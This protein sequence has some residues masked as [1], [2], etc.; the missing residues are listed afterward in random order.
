ME[1]TMI[2]L[3]TDPITNIM[4]TNPKDHPYVI[5]GEGRNAT[6]IYFETQENKDKYLQQF[7]FSAAN[8]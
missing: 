1:R 8:S 3:V 7:N 5:K 4:V 2:V 6:K